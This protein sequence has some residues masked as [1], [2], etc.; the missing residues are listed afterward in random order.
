MLIHVDT[1]KTELLVTTASHTYPSRGLSTTL[2]FTQM[3]GASFPVVSVAKVHIVQQPKWT[4]SW[5]RR[6]SNRLAREGDDPPN[7]SKVTVSE[8]THMNG[9]RELTYSPAVGGAPFP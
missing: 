9:D 5:L 2:T 6:R 8:W 1:E 4:R 3:A 7:R